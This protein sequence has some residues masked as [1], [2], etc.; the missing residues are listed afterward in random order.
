MQD[1]QL[2]SEAL[3]AIV[4]IKS[5]PEF[6]LFN[7]FQSEWL[8]LTKS[9]WSGWIQTFGTLVAL[10]IAILIPFCLEIFKYGV[11]EKARKSDAIFFWHDRIKLINK[12]LECLI[13]A[14]RGLSKCD[15][16]FPRSPNVSQLG[17]IH[18]LSAMH[19]RIRKE[20][21]D[22]LREIEHVSQE[23]V[24]NAQYIDDQ[25][26]MDLIIVHGTANRC[27]DKVENSGDL[28]DK[29]SADR[30]MAKEKIEE[31]IALHTRSLEV[32]HQYV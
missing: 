2:L 5:T 8:C 30:K 10:I 4:K 20:V 13:S 18:L 31:L 14:Q 32:L 24:K 26:A 11:E 23:D 1:D 16:E 12:N 6:C 22:R 25:L 29:E 17:Q 27:A 9:E 19:N 3:K 21:V 15:L 7:Q 28:F